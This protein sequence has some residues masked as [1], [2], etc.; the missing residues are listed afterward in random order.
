M[1][2]GLITEA[3]NA[4]PLSFD[5][6]SD[7]TETENVETKRLSL[8]IDITSSKLFEG[9]DDDYLQSPMSP[10]F[11]T[12]ETERG[13]YHGP[14]SDASRF[15]Q[16]AVRAVRPTGIY[17]SGAVYTGRALAEWAIVVGECNNFVE[18]RRDEGVLGM[19]E[20]EVPMLT[21]EGLG[22]R[23]RG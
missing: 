20:V 4:R 14:G 9:A 11:D 2:T 17:A 23:Q 10:S 6:S 12:T 15:Q 22:L 21:V 18:R 3:R 5:G 19:A 16:A 8:N 7:K 1:Q 13:R